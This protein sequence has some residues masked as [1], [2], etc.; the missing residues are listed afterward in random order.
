MLIVLGGLPGA[1]KT[2]LARAVSWHL[3][4][5][6]IRIDTIEQAVRS[7][8]MLRSEVGPAGY[9]VAYAVAEDNLR[10]GRTVVAD[11][12]NPLAVTREAWRAVAARVSSSVVEIEIV[13][14]DRDEH[15]RV[16]ETRSSDVAGLTPPTWAQV[17]T[18]SYE[19]WD[20]PHVV[21]DT[22]FKTVDE[23]AQEVLAA[24]EQASREDGR[25]SLPDREVTLCAR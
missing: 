7:S 6:H 24:I 2:T 17:T 11:S 3:Q 13:R 23:S 18:H 25:L 22:S 15:R 1:G 4:A 9:M 14:S 20:R 10:V 19:P 8:G 5:A 12:V 21:I 16:I